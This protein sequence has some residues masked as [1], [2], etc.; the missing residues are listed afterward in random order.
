MRYTKSS[1]T[2]GAWLDK[3]TVMSGSKG[4]LVSE[5]VPIEKSYEGE[6]RKQDI[7]KIRIEG[8]TEAKNVSINK[9][10]INGLIEA[11][12]EESKDWINKPLTIHIEKTMISGKRLPVLYLIPNGFDLTEDDNG[13]LVITRKGI[14]SDDIPVIEDEVSQEELDIVF[15]GPK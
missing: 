12:G 11:Y 13:Y 4:K 6:I 9:P 14:Q 2:Q 3:K 1:S 10:T 8:D 5:T 15:P 7:A